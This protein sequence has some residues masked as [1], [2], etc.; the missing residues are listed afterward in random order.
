MGKLIITESSGVSRELALDKERVSIGRHADND[1]CLNDKA[2]SGHHAVIITILSDSFLEDLD[3]TNGTL[4]NG[5]QIA[6]HPLSN[7]DTV[8]IGRNSL[9]YEG[10]QQ[11]S[12]EDFEKTMILRPAQ[13]AAAMNTPVVAAGSENKPL[14]GRLRVEGGSNAGREL[15]LTK[16]LT[17]IGK[18]GVQVAAITKRADGFYIVH[19]GGAAGGRRPL[20]NGTEIDQQAR[21][22]NANDLIE[23]AGTQMKFILA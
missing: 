23:L 4:V 5:K 8:S 11:A 19:V 2:V 21:R 12:G 6:K 3:S 13:M 7:G 15:E 17:T 16:A 9:R 14:T 20:V 1:I 22:L 18:P 10:D